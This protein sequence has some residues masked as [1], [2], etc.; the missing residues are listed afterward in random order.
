M[1]IVET[2]AKGNRSGSAV[3]APNHS[4]V[5]SLHGPAGTGPEGSCTQRRQ[6]S[7]R[8]GFSDDSARDSNLDAGCVA[9]H[10]YTH[11]IGC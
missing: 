11:L 7:M 1:R 8:R 2:C 3:V 5:D 9:L 10:K 4:Q 6:D